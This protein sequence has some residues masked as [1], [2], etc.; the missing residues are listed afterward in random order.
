MAAAG[1]SSVYVHISAENRVY[2]YCI[3]DEIGR[4]TFGTVFRAKKVISRVQRL[5]S[6]R[7]KSKDRFAIKVVPT[8]SLRITNPNESGAVVGHSAEVSI[9]QVCVIKLN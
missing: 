3:R 7:N 2:K 1:S 4:G 6:F 9:T 8:V 5:L